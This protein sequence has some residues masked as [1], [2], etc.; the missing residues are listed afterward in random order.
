MN[1]NSEQLEIILFSMS[2]ST[3]IYFYSQNALLITNKLKE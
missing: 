3:H 1:Q 2:M